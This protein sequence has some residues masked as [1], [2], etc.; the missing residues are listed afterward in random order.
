MTYIGYA[1]GYKGFCFM[2]E[3]NSIFVSTTAMFDET[4]Y[5]HCSLKPK[6]CGFT[7]IEGRRTKPPPNDDGIIEDDSSIP[8]DDNDIPKQPHC[9]PHPSIEEPEVPVV[10]P[11]QT[12]TPPVTPPP[13][14]WETV[15][16][17]RQAQRP[18][19]RYHV[20]AE[21]HQVLLESI[22]WKQVKYL[23]F[24]GPRKTNQ[25]GIHTY[26]SEG[27]MCG[28]TQGYIWAQRYEVNYMT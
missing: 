6:P 13:I 17:P 8:E 3:K 22:F 14:R 28:I 15:Q 4:V 25:I 9:P 24:V 2:M 12:P 23:L 5:P 18:P 11:L 7:S 19:A 20:K 27:C 21:F 1:E 26:R 10:P 16:E